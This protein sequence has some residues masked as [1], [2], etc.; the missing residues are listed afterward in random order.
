MMDDDSVIVIVGGYIYGWGCFFLGCPWR[1][2]LRGALGV[3]LVGL[4]AVGCV[5]GVCM[6]VCCV[7]VFCV[8]VLWC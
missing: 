1:S 2:V 4:R 6:Y 3:V 5:F 8:A 7:W